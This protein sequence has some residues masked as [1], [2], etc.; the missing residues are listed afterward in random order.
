MA[1]LENGTGSA[2]EK[3]AA[4]QVP[5]DPQPVDKQLAE[6][7]NDTTQAVA[8]KLS[9]GFW[10]VAGSGFGK[11]ALIVA[12]VVITGAA[13]AMGGLAYADFAF[14]GQ[15]TPLVPGLTDTFVVEMGKMS[16]AQGLWEGAKMGAASLL[17][18]FGLAALTGGGLLGAVAD[19]RAQQ[20]KLQTE[21]A[22]E[23]SR[24]REA[25]RGLEQMRSGEQEHGMKPAEAV[26][27]VQVEAQMAQPAAAPQPIQP[28]DHFAAAQE[29]P[30][31][32]DRF[33]PRCV[34]TSPEL[35]YCTRELD[36]RNDATALTR[37]A[38]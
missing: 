5:A 36:R 31:F 17:N 1:L 32:R 13:L 11:G 37:G 29:R 15:A 20:A 18:G 26:T 14:T 35:S 19:T 6:M 24:T 21:L 25:M 10:S 2:I 12:A 34:D 3:L 23:R 9:D 30:R 4:A 8:G 7:G 16:F 33:T 38:I 22:E 27:H 28:Q